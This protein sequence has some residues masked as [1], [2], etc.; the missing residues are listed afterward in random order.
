[1]R[2]CAAVAVIILSIILAYRPI[3]A[4]AD[5]VVFV[6]AF[7]WDPAD[8]EMGGLSAILMRDAGAHAFALSDR[9]VL[10][11]LALMRSSGQIT[12]VEKQGVTVLVDDTESD[13]AV[14]DSEGLAFGP[15]NA[16]YVSFEQDNLIAR[17]DNVTGQKDGVE[18]PH[19]FRDLGENK[20]L[21]ALAIDANGDLFTLPERP[22]TLGQGFAVWHWDGTNW[23]QPFHLGA[24][25]GF[26]AVS[27][28]FGPDGRFYL[29]ERKVTIFGFQSRI[30]RWEVTSQRPENEL[31]LLTTRPG[32]FANLEGLSVWENPTGNTM[33][34]MVSDDNFW[35]FMRTQIVEYA[36]T[37]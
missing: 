10:F 2:L 34:T 32:Q 24:R 7:T 6:G 22:R 26:L 17:Y 3:A 25:D 27:A 4:G 35:P 31:V 23:T 16:I 19:S 37:E 5:G 30:R 11:E 21:E 18:T 13:D 33:L 15:D 8:P 12:A 29:L 36:L 1:M 20:G 14:F 9:A 28:E